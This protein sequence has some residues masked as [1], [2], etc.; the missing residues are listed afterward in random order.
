MSKD[1]VGR[2]TPLAEQAEQAYE[3]A[4]ARIKLAKQLEFQSIDFSGLKFLERLPSQLSELSGLRRISLDGTF[5]H[6]LRPLETLSQLHWLSINNTQAS[7]LSPLAK[8]GELIYLSA[9]RTKV[10]D[11]SPIRNLKQLE[12]LS[13]RRTLVRNIGALQELHNLKTLDLYWTPIRNISGISGLINLR[14]LSLERTKVEDISELASLNEL[15]ALNLY[16]TRITS[17]KA[18]SNHTRLRLLGIGRT[19]VSDLSPISGMTSLADAAVAGR[20]AYSHF[21]EFYDTPAYRGER[22]KEKATGVR[23]ISLREPHRTVRLINSYRTAR[24]LAPYYPDGYESE[25]QEQ[26][27]SPQREAVAE[28]L[29]QTSASYSFGFRNGLLEAHPQMEAPGHPD[30][31]ADIH[32]EVLDKLQDAQTRL[33]N[34]PAR[35]RSTVERLVVALGPELGSVKP[36][37]LLMR[38]RSLEA[39]IAAYDTEEGRS[40]IFPDSLSILKDLDSSLQDLKGCFPQL[41]EIEA[42]RLAQGLLDAGV[43]EALHSMAGMR[44]AAATSGIMTF[45]AVEALKAGEPDIQSVRDILLQT[46]DLSVRAKAIKERAAIAGQMLLD[47]RNF[48]ASVLREASSS[49]MVSRAAKTFSKARAD[50]EK[51]GSESWDQAVKAIPPAIGKGVA[52]GVEEVTSAAIKTGAVGLAYTIGGWLG[53]LGLLV[54]SFGP[55]ARKADE[56]KTEIDQTVENDAA[57]EN[58]DDD[59][60]TEPNGSNG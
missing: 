45:S 22:E 43:D 4:E 37:I 44:D 50:F 33:G 56:L 18:L 38:S 53:A 31:A 49:L 47:Y 54:T 8:L 5:I 17:I 3:A 27:F 13:L 7:D 14:Q 36:G 11:L 46:T 39:D 48:A 16:W 32:A 19:R 29:K 6:D 55:L 21:V 23:V 9:D 35:I 20:H 24:D 15:Q 26:T 52:R 30:L 41:V 25:P 10:F 34:A 59:Q 60:T 42:T 51:V 2:P 1:A 57:Q 40:E 12:Y 58:R 28:G